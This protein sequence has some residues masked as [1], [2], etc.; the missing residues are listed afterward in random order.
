MLAREALDYEPDVQSD[1]APPIHWSLR[2][3]KQQAMG[4]IA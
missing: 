1:T 3:L 2:C 4:V